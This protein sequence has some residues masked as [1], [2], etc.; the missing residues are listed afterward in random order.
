MILYSAPASPF[1]RKV[2]IAASVLGLSDQMTIKNVDMA[3]PDDTLF[4]QNPLGKIPALSLDDGT[5]LFDSRVIVEYLD[6]IA[7]GNKIF[8]PAGIDRYKDLALNAMADGMMDASIL[9]IYEVRMRPQEGRVQ[10]W[11]DYQAAKVAR[12]LKML[13]TNPPS[14]EDGI[15]IGHISLAC[16][17]GYLDFRFNGDWREDHPNLVNWLETFSGLVAAFDKTRPPPG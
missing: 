13:E 15:T 10:S 1:G 3:N 14:L 7:T 5:A 6:S 2:K 16:L 12:G 9:R 8:L 17:L 11:V 4:S